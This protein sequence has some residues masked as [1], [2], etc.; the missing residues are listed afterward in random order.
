VVARRFGGVVLV[1]CGVIL[2]AA[3]G[4]SGPA[5]E[6]APDA[7]CDFR[8]S[9]ADFTAAILVS[10]E[11]E[12]FPACR[13][14][15]FFRD[16]PLD[17]TDLVP[18]EQ[19]IFFFFETPFTPTITGTPTITRTRTPSPLTTNTPT[20]TRTP[21]VTRTRTSTHT[22]TPTRTNTP[23]RT[24]TQTGTPTI[25][26]TPTVTRTPTG[27]AQRLSGE[28]AANWGNQI[29]FL[30]GMPFSSLPDVIYRVTASNNRLNIT[31]ASGFV[32]GTNLAIGTDGRVNAFLIVP[33]TICLLPP[34]RVLEYAF[35]YQFIFN[36]DGSGSA[37]V[38]WTYGRDSLCATCTVLDQ[39][40]LQ[41]IGNVVSAT[42][43]AE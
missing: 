29:C 23:T 7:N 35:D 42:S 16:R 31:T 21:S 13:A 4:V 26:R 36:L 5:P 30:D 27:I 20:I 37:A 40:V 38:E 15:D 18:I 33:D 28:W 41:R 8:T 17:E 22:A 10:V 11:P 9:A 39:A 43:V 3:R 2:A 1:V 12:R 19:E 32:I 6:G 14:A 25:T 24:S 34:N